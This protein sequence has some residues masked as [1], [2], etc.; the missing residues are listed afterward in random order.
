MEGNAV[1]S[2]IASEYAKSNNMMFFETSAKTADKV[3]DSFIEFSKKLLPKKRPL[4]P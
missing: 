3:N 1:S 2:E 4:S